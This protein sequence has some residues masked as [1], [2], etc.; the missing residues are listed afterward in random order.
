MNK[1]LTITR[2]NG[3]QEWIGFQP[4]LGAR[5]L[6]WFAGI[7]AVVLVAAVPAMAQFNQGGATRGGSPGG[8]IDIAVGNL[9]GYSSLHKFG[10]NTACS[11]VEEDIWLAGGQYQFPIST[12]VVQIVSG[13][14]A[15]DT[16]AGTGA[17]SIQIEGLGTDWR[18]ASA[19]LDTAG[20]SA[21]LVSTV[22]FIR[23]NRAFVV[24]IGTYSSII[25]SAANVGLITVISTA[26]GN[27]VVAIGAAKGQSQMGIYT[28]PAGKTGYLVSTQFNVSATISTTVSLYKRENADDVVSPFSS[29]RL[30]VQNDELRGVDDRELIVPVKLSAKTDIWA[31][32]LAVSGTPAATVEFDIIMKDDN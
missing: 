27:T 2:E 22:A 26:T 23:V 6:R 7:F 25:A 21:S 10:N 16:A 31:T 19:R 11:I 30:L 15:A 24:D 3:T 14:N 8:G 4:S 32:C 29:K 17:R 9:P 28:I 18:M 20:A 12:S 1:P 13:G 5:L